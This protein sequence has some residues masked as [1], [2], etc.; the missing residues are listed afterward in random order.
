MK[1]QQGGVRQLAVAEGAVV[2][3]NAKSEGTQSHFDTFRGLLAFQ[4]VTDLLEPLSHGLLPEWLG[5]H[6][7]KEPNC[8]RDAG[9]WNG[10]PLA[11]KEIA[12]LQNILDLRDRLIEFDRP[13]HE[14][15]TAERKE[16]LAVR[17]GWECAELLEESLEGLESD[18]PRGARYPLRT[19]TARLL[20]RQRL[21]NGLDCSSWRHAAG[22]KVLVVI[23]DQDMSAL[24]VDVLQ[25]QGMCECKRG[26]Y[27]S[28]GLKA[29]R[30]LRPEL[31]IVKRCPSAVGVRLCRDLAAD[32]ETAAIPV[33]MISGSFGDP[34]RAEAIAAGASAFLRLPFEVEAL[35]ET[36]RRAARKGPCIPAYPRRR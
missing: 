27:G 15:F 6:S 33:I 23:D 14:A 30:V 25:R 2:P 26:I 35:T 28:L 4:C 29:A 12:A 16:A 10:M 24:F 19:F 1:D 9:K 17:F 5:T 22:I 18:L 34:I 8:I 21:W 32:R 7:G 20:E 31:I 11:L 3:M 36:V 13:K